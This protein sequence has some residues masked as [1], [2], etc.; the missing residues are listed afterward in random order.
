[1]GLD[2]YYYRRYH[3]PATFGEQ[4]ETIDGK[5]IPLS[6][7]ELRSRTVEELVGY[8]R[9]ANAIHGW[10]VD[11]IA[12]GVD[13]CQEIPLDKHG[14]LALIAEIHVALDSGEGLDPT[15]G[16]FFGSKEK[17]E[18]WRDCLIQARDIAV[19]LLDDMEDEKPEG[20]Y[21]QWYY[22]ASW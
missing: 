4:V 19:W 14:L 2:M 21:I 5:K 8:Q 9:K 16:F 13:E 15:P 22:Q 10:I 12:E 7:N 18:Y 17:D 6:N 20:V 11:N 1:M 3:T